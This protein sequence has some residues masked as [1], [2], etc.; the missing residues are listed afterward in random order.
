MN[1]SPSDHPDYSKGSV[2]INSESNTISQPEHVFTDPTTYKILNGDT[3]TQGIGEYSQQPPAFKFGN[4]TNLNIYDD[5]GEFGT[6][7][8][9]I[10]HVQICTF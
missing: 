1:D 5:I 3:N 10:S 4:D 6:G 7:M 9:L 8:L 2:N